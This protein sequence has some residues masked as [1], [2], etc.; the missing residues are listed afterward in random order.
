MREDQSF[1]DADDLKADLGKLDAHFWG[2]PDDVKTSGFFRFAAYPPDDQ[3]FLTTRLWDKHAPHWRENQGKA[4]KKSRDKE[5][6]AKL[7]AEMKRIQDMA[8]S[9]P[10][11]QAAPLTREDTMF[12]QIIHTPLRRKGKWTRYP[13]DV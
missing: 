4:S 11:I 7:V 3:S 9:A 6:E 13:D 8:E 12:V 5:S 1:V 10:P 2:M